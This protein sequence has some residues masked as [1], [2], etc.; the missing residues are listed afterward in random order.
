M[1]WL[2]ARFCMKEAEREARRWLSQASDDRRFAEWV[3]S[4]GR[5]YDKGCFVAQQAGE[6]FLATRGI[7]AAG[8]TP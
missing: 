2:R 4:E 7:S 1:R 5:F 6:G 8:G 3:L